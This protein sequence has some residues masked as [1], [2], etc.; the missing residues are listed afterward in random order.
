MVN[1]GNPDRIFGDLWSKKPC[2]IRCS[3]ERRRP[4]RE[5]RNGKM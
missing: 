2:G 5:A 1:S 4:P 3:R